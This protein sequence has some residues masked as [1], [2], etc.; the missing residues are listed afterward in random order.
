MESRDCEDLRELT[1]LPVA[2]RI[3]VASRQRN[4]ISTSLNRNLPSKGS[5]SSGRQ[6]CIH[7]SARIMT[8]NSCRW[9]CHFDDDNYVNIYRLLAELDRHDPSRPLYLGKSSRGPT[10][11]KDAISGD[12]KARVVF[13]FGTGGAGFCLTR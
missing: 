10:K 2:E 7:R 6:C 9:Y 5:N 1:V 12:Q 4:S 13:S 3:C 11:L 8:L